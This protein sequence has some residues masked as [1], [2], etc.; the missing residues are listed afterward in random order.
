MMMMMMM[1][2]TMMNEIRDS[3]QVLLPESLQDP[4]TVALTLTIQSRGPE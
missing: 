4:F 3:F 2:M 1:M